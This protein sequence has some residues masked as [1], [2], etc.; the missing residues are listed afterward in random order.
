MTETRS[1]S[2][3]KGA[4][5]M[6]VQDRWGTV[7]RAIFTIWGRTSGRDLQLWCC[8]NAANRSPGPCLASCGTVGAAYVDNAYVVGSGQSKR[9]D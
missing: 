2:P 4:S 1:S 6:G 5:L 3:Q 9:Q 8:E 7:S